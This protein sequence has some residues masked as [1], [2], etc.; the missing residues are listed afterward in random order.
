[1]QMYQG[2]TNKN[3]FNMKEIITM[4]EINVNELNE[5]AGGANGNYIRYTVKK[6]DCLSVLAVQYH[7]TVD[8]L[9]KINN[10]KNPDLIRIGQVLLIPV[11]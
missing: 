10:I 6:G 4:S 2:K 9:V 7:T 1:M 11:K 8:E 5:V 3:N